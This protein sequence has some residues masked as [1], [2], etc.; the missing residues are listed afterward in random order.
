MCLAVCSIRVCP[1]VQC[2][3]VPH[4]S[5]SV[6]CRNVFDR[7]HGLVACVRCFWQRAVLVSLIS[8]TLLS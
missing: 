1:T 7:D 6:Q 4:V 8:E 5:G 3:G 2:P